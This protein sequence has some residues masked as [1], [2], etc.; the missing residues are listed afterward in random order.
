[1]KYFILRQHLLLGQKFQLN[2]WQE[3]IDPKWICFRD[4]YKI[5]RRCV[6]T[7]S[8]GENIP[9]PNIV[10]TPFLLFSKLIMDV[11]ELYGEPVYRRDIII[12]NEQDQQRKQYYLVMLETIGEGRVLWEESNLFCMEINNQKE[13]VISQDFA[14]SIL[15][16]GVVGIALKEIEMR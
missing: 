5:P 15:R 9:F 12:I 3:K 10:I 13:I 7:A 8:L 2:N 4:F 6:F 1:M 14:E 11:V 16:R